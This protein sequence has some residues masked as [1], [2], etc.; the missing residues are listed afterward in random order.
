MPSAQPHKSEIQITPSQY[1]EFTR[2]GTGTE[3]NLDAYHDFCME[4]GVSVAREIRFRLSNL[5]GFSDTELHQ[6]APANTTAKTISAEKMRD[7]IRSNLLAVSDYSLEEIHGLSKAANDYITDII[8]DYFPGEEHA[9]MNDEVATCNDPAKLF[10]LAFNDKYSAKIKF[11]AARKLLIMQSIK[12]IRDF[13]EQEV[14]D[15]DALSY[16]TDFFND[17]MLAVP[18]GGRIGDLTKRFLISYHDPETLQTMATEI[19]EVPEVKPHPKWK[20]RITPLDC[21][22]ALVT[23]PQTGREMS[24]LFRKHPRQKTEHSRLTKALRF[25][26]MIGAINNDLNGIRLVFTN[27]NDIEGF[28]SEFKKKL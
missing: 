6:I 25:G 27:E 18:E 5:T 2:I 22:T 15:E 8:K 24:V 28:I 23:D 26:T 3:L 13:S 17:R 4:N 21:R 19:S 12:E 10:L 14:D 9:Q 1:L 11:E 20:V 7:D 16:M